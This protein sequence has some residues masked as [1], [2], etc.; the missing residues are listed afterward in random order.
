M[1]DDE[2][3]QDSA[4]SPARGM[5]SRAVQVF[6]IRIFNAVSAS[7]GQMSVANVCMFMAAVVMHYSAWHRMPTCPL[8]GEES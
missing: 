8:I 1:I 6:V 2:S 4:A 7:I 3:S 5:C